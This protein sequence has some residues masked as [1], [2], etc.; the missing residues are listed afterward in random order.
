[1]TG[2]HVVPYDL[3]EL[4]SDERDHI[5]NHWTFFVSIHLSL[6]GLALISRRHITIFERFIALLAYGGFAVMNFTAQEGN[7]AYLDALLAQASAMEDVIPPA[8]GVAIDVKGFFYLD[9]VR[10]AL[11]YLYATAASFSVLLLL[12]INVV[13]GSQKQGRDRVEPTD[14]AVL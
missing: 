8:N 7:Y 13:S 4:I 9:E 6:I 3:L 12:L 5:Y 11:P 2:G 1:M 10:Q 14:G